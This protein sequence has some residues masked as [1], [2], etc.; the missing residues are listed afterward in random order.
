MW[1]FFSQK[2]NQVQFRFFSQAK[3]KRKKRKKFGVGS[4]MNSLYVYFLIITSLIF[5]LLEND[6][7]HL[8]FTC[9]NE[10]YIY[11]CDIVLSCY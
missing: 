4:V 3:K 10:L 9:Y 5:E 1:L 7:L 2:K 8:L 11:I 6:L